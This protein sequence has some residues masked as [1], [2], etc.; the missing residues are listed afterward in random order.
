MALTTMNPS[1]GW[2]MLRSEIRMSNSRS[3]IK[4]KASAT[5]AAVVTTKPCSSRIAGSISRI[6]SSSSTKR[7]RFFASD[8]PFGIGI[9]DLFGIDPPTPAGKVTVQQQTRSDDNSA[10]SEISHHCLDPNL[11]EMCLRHPQ[12][13][14][15]ASLH[16]VS[17]EFHGASDTA[18]GGREPD[19]TVSGLK[20]ATSG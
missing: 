10:S 2:P 5:D 6:L 11:P 4:L 8:S 16:Q 12:H 17:E 3:V 1:A 19:F 15:R 9:F 13:P 20:R 7:T 14:H 18:S